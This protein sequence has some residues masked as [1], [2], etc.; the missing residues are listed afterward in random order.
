MSSARRPF[1]AFFLTTILSTSRILYGVFACSDFARP[2]EAIHLIVP[3]S[4]ARTWPK[5]VLERTGWAKGAGGT[6]NVHTA[7]PYERWDDMVC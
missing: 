6:G 3:S 1:Q 4:L 7:H 2:E 5:E